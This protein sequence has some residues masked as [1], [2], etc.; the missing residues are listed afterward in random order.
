MLI[1]PPAKNGAKTEWNPQSDDNFEGPF[2]HFA[3][4]RLPPLK[5]LPPPAAEL[6][7]R[8]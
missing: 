8:T 3:G 7:V 2:V 1:A 4:K 6:L 5:M